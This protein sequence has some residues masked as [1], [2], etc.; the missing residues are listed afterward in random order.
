MLRSTLFISLLAFSATAAAQGFG[1]S[2]IQGSYGTVEVDIGGG[3]NV[4]G[5]GFGV[6]GSYALTDQFHFSGE[7]QTADM[8]FGVDLSILE[9]AAGYHTG[10]SDQLDFTAQ[11]GYVNT[12]VESGGVGVDDDGLMLGVGLRG[13]LTDALE[14]NGGVDYID[15]DLG[16]GE[17]RIGAGFLY[18]IADNLTVGAKASLWDDIDVYQ[19]NLRFDFE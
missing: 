18:D 9:L 15:F 5:D 8:D 1:Y 7:Y 3:A 11:L 19:L 14:V 2:Y 10:L 6:S 13:A 16:G 4:D 12:E 17:T